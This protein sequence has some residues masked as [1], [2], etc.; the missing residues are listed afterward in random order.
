MLELSS[1]SNRTAANQ[2]SRRRAWILCLGLADN[3]IDALANLRRGQLVAFDRDKTV[4]AIASGKAIG[5]IAHFDPGK[6]K[7]EHDHPDEGRARSW[8][9]RLPRR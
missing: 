2:I 5:A 6:S 4:F 1:G 3:L 7:G 8:N 9:V